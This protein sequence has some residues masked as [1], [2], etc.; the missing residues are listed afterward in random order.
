MQDRELDAL[1][2][3]NDAL[4]EVIEHSASF[5]H[6]NGE[7]DCHNESCKLSDRVMEPTDIHESLLVSLS[8]T[9]SENILPKSPLLDM[10]PINAPDHQKFNLGSDK[11]LNDNTEECK[12]EADM[13]L[14]R[15]VF[16]DL[17]LF[18]ENRGQNERAQEFRMKAD[19]LKQEIEEGREPL[20][21]I[22][23][24]YE[25]LPDKIVEE[26]TRLQHLGYQN[27]KDNSSID[28]FTSP[29][30]Y[31]NQSHESK[32]ESTRVVHPHC[33]GFK[34]CKKSKI[35]ATFL[36]VGFFV[37]YLAAL[38]FVDMKDLDI[39]NF[40]EEYDYDA[41]DHNES[42][43]DRV[44]ALIKSLEDS[45]VDPGLTPKNE[46]K[47]CR[48]LEGTGNY[49]KA[50]FCYES[51][52]YG[53]DLEKAVHL[54]LYRTYKY[55][56]QDTEAEK[57]LKTYT[58]LE[59]NDSKASINLA[60]LYLKSGNIQRA[61]N[62]LKVVAESDPE[63]SYVHYQLFKL[64]KDQWNLEQ[65]INSALNYL[66]TH[67]HD[68]K[69]R[70]H[71][72]FTYS[73]AGL[74]PQAIDI[75]EQL[76]LEDPKDVAALNN[77][78]TALCEIEEFQNAD[79]SFDNAIN[80]D[81]SINTSL[82]NKARCQQRS[83]NDK[84]ALKSAKEAMGIDSYDVSARVLYALLHKSL[85]MKTEALR[86]LNQTVKVN[87]E[88]AEPVILL[89]D[90]LVENRDFQNAK[91]HLLHAISLEPDNSLVL[92]NLGKVYNHYEQHELAKEHLNK[93]FDKHHEIVYKPKANVLEFI[94]VRE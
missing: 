87:P 52:V 69:F 19:N 16:K 43:H 60:S 78:A 6:I 35:K 18:F 85:G 83:G 92:F 86:I 56:N 36:M 10:A 7:L 57:H 77:L 64:Y 32:D 84:A 53:E 71:L 23:Q 3:N 29:A 39:D 21:N 25:N 49:F 34:K 38:C 17:A 30:E 88:M 11:T 80:A 61:I 12:I 45:R 5:I 82:L 89:S 28:E 68:R 81:I 22:D 51:M 8:R 27:P 42:T 26:N 14:R 4:S 37:A 65:A 1:I 79:E 48:L 66:K 75:Y 91:K 31:S 9:N 24:N 46:L 13:K 94:E 72:A 2:H 40:I 73:Q 54:G 33:K 20:S 93:A 44:H 74:Y 58:E 62:C 15:K 55:L 67:P 59:P 63:N 41:S 90:I 76:I 50:A 47:L 70:H